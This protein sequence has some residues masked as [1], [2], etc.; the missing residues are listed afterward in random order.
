MNKR[1]LLG[2]WRHVVGLPR[3]L[4]QKR[5]NDS[6]KHTSEF[7][8]TFM[9]ADHHR[10]RDFAVTELPRTGAPLA[11]GGIAARL[12]LPVE[13][14]RLILDELEKNMT[15]L[16][17]NPQGEVIWAYPVTVEPTPHRVKFSSGEEVY[18]A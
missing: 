17:R 16:F 8:L 5:V 10:V 11:P 14:V 13:R 12:N 2:V 7:D 18:A 4:W 1:M 9:S 15:F 6:A 3:H